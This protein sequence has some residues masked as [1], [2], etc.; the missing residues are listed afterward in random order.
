M[1]VENH[2][3]KVDSLVLV[4]EGEGLGGLVESAELD[5]LVDA[6]HLSKLAGW[7]TVGGDDTVVHEVALVRCLGIVVTI[8]VL[9]VA[10]HLQFACL[11]VLV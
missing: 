8:A 6:L 9:V 10:V 7:L 5:V 4:G 11:L 3:L 2:A 1:P